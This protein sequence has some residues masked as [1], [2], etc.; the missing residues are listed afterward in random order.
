MTLVSLKIIN[1]CN[2]NS[3]EFYLSQTEDDIAQKKASQAQLG[4]TAPEKPMA[5][6]AVLYLVRIKTIKKVR[7]VSLPS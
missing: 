4:G 2:R 6:R 3:K 5:S 7:D 1:I